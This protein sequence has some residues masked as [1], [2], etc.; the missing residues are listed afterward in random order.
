MITGDTALKNII[1]A[2]YSEDCLEQIKDAADIV[3]VIGEQV[4]LQRSGINYKGLCPFHNE[5][6]PSFMVNPERRSFHCFGCGEGGNVFTFMMKYFQLTFPEAVKKLAERYHVQLPEKEFSAVEQARLNKRN[7]LYEVN[8]K[9]VAIYHDFLLNRPG[10]AG[11]RKYLAQRGISPEVTAAFQLGYAPESWD[12]ICKKFSSPAEIR[13]AAADAGLIVANKRGG[14]YDRFRDRVLCPLFDISGRVIG[15]G[16]R[17]LG[18]G[19]PK[20]LNSPESPVYNKSRELFGLYQ[21]KKEIRESRQVILVEGNFDL[22]SLVDYGIKNVCAPL[23]T[24]LTRQQV[25]I[26]K[27]YC[28]EAVLLFDGDQAGLKAAMRAVPL[29]LSE[30][31]EARIVIL[32]AEHDPDTFVNDFGP[33]KLREKIAGADSLPEFVFSRLVA[34]HGLSLEGKG[35]IVSELRPLLKAIGDDDLQRS[36]FAAHFSRK[37]GLQ[38]EQLLDKFSTPPAFSRE[39]RQPAAHRLSLPLKQRQLLEFLIFYPEFFSEFLEAGLEMVLVH[40][41]AAIILEEMKTICCRENVSP[42]DR[43]LDA[44]S[45]PERSLISAIMVSPPAWADGREKELAGEMLSWIREQKTARE[46]AALI[47]RINEAQLA[48]D[49]ILLMELLSRKKEMDETSAK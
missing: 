16:G 5:K 3:E 38:P 2:L 28:R 14:F 35:R 31:L 9:A 27:R 47:K 24:A 13:Q 44:L 17:I 20:Y 43:L 32:P 42:A 18:Q 36:V 29:F 45:G 39:E 1:M 10:G 34:E 46:S 11:A 12:F 8:K 7:R 22:L 26:L 6:T 48:N 21:N 4:K 30:Q 33:E 19:E 25:K 41:S 37:L 40:E 15:F 49:E 23:G